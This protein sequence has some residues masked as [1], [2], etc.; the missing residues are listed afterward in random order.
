FC[1]WLTKEVGVAAIPLSVF[2]A[3]AFPHK[4]IRLCFAKQEA[5]LRAAAERLCTL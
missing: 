2:C 1:Q 4:L 3:D 5:T